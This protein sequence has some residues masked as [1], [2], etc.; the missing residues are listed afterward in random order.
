MVV[1]EV[2]K[3]A[4]NLSIP[5]SNYIACTRILFNT[6]KALKIPTIIFINKLD[7]LGA[8]SYKVIDDIKKNMSDKVVGL[9]E[10]YNEGGKDVSVSELFKSDLVME[11]I[12]EV[13]ADTDEAFLEE[14]INGD[15][16]DKDT[17][18]EKLSDFSRRGDIYPIFCGAASIGLGINNLLD[19][20]CEFLPIA[21][22]DSSS[23]LS[24]V[25]FKII[26]KIP[27]IHITE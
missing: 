4:L 1:T 10:V 3:Q 19:G 18:E 14:Y 5:I 25:V 24:V 11:N 6:L 27:H 15:K 20:I 8:N 26:I 7:R 9:Q 13:L 17:I 12:L 16:H 22:K 2:E 21:G 23:D